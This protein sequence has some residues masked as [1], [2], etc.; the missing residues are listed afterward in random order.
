VIDKPQAVDAVARDQALPDS[1][2]RGSESSS[3]CA[4]LT[5]LRERAEQWQTQADA[6]DLIRD[7]LA[8]L[9][10][11]VEHEQGDT[12]MV[13]KAETTDSPTAPA[14]EADRT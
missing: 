3:S 9:E 2:P 10:A 5:A 12:R 6:E 14:N 1:T 11:Q 8:R 13:T 7:L 4:S